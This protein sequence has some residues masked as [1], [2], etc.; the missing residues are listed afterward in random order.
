MEKDYA[1]FKEKDLF[2]HKFASFLLRIL[3]RRFVIK[4]GLFIDKVSSFP[5]KNREV[6]TQINDGASSSQGIK[7]TMT[8]DLSLRFNIF[9]SWIILA[10]N[11][12]DPKLTE[13]Q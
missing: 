2:R 7:E 12:Q 8:S 3:R 9:Y 4:N 6:V 11:M 10:K 1:L 13:L 5:N